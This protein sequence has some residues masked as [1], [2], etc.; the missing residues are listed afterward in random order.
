MNVYVVFYYDGCQDA[1]LVDNV[2]Y[3]RADADERAKIYN[4]YVLTREVL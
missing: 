3:N 1:W 4:G 2:Y